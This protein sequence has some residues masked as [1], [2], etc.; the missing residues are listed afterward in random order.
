MYIQVFGFELH[1]VIWRVSSMDLPDDGHSLHDGLGDQ[2]TL[3]GN[4]VRIT[5]SGLA[6]RGGLR[7]SLGRAEKSFERVHSKRIM[8]R[9]FRIGYFAIGIGILL[10]ISYK[11]LNQAFITKLRA[12]MPSLDVNGPPA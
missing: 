6:R 9:N 8:K 12:A 10:K 11:L 4:S 5:N 2:L 7:P 3:R 1:V